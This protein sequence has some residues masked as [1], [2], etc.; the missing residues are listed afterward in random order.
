M[1]SLR[2]NGAFSERDTGVISCVLYV[3][4]LMSERRMYGVCVRELSSGFVLCHQLVA[5]LYWDACSPGPQIGKD[6]NITTLYERNHRQYF[7]TGE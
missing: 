3:H 6:G 2:E 7:H 1:G 5:C 4:L